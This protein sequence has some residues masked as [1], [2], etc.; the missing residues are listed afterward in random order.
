MISVGNSLTN[1]QFLELKLE[2]RICLCVSPDNVSPIG[3]FENAMDTKTIS[4]GRS[5]FFCVYKNLT[6]VLFT[7]AIF[8][9]GHQLYFFIWQYQLIMIFFFIVPV[10][11]I[12]YLRL[13]VFLNLKIPTLYCVKVCF[14]PTIFPLVWL[15]PN[16]KVIICWSFNLSSL[17]NSKWD[18][19]Y[20]F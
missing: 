10:N 17:L 1:I 6:K 2:Y 12:L 4:G 9:Y 20:N 7:T 8:Q 16:S 11:M 13:A 18:F 3:K 14:S 19:P 5:L 15:L